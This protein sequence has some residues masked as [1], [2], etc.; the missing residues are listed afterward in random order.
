MRFLICPY[1]SKAIKTVLNEDFIR[2]S[3]HVP[4][5]HLLVLLT[6]IIAIPLP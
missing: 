2:Q 5:K 6:P 3:L 1:Y 4:I